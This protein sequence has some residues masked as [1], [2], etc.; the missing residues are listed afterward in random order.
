MFKSLDQIREDFRKP[1]GAEHLI[2]VSIG[3]NYGREA[4]YPQCDRSALFAKIAGTKTLTRETITLI[5]QL[6]YDVQVVT[7]VKEL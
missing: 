3:R 7:S 5:K 2:K 4:I 6:G 1:D